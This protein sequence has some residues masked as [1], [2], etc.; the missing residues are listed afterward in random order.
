MIPFEELTC[1]L[2]P[3]VVEYLVGSAVLNNISTVHKYYTVGDLACKLHFVSY[4]NH[5][6]LF[7]RKALYYL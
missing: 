6:H 1:T 7:F 4:D 5:S 2:V 3:A